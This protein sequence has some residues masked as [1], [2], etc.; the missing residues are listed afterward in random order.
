MTSWTYSCCW[1]DHRNGCPAQ[2]IEISK[3][4]NTRDGW[5]QWHEDYHIARVKRG[6]EQEKSAEKLNIE[7]DK[8]W[9]LSQEFRV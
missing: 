8:I 2:D 7:A 1:T 6:Y 9:Q 5:H 4:A 3:Y